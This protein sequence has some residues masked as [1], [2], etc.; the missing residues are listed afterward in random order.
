MRDV[1]VA[2]RAAPT[3]GPRVDAAVWFFLRLGMTFHTQF[4]ES[5]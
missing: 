3:V 2:A 1:A 4:T 5:R